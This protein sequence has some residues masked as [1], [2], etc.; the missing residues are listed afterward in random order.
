MITKKTTKSFFSIDSKILLLSS[1]ILYFLLPYFLL[2]KKFHPCP[3]IS[4][5]KETLGRIQIEIHVLQ[6]NPFILFS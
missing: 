5:K 3:C 2:K 6:R 4:V 1:E